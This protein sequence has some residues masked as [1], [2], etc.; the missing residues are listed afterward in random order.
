MEEEHWQGIRAP[1]SVKLSSLTYLQLSFGLWSSTS[2]QEKEAWIKSKYVEKRFLKKMSG[3]EALVEGER[4]ARPWTVKK[5]QRNNSSVRAPNRARRK[6]HRYEP[7]SASPANLSAGQCG[8]LMNCSV[9][10]WLMKSKS[11]KI[12]V[13]LDYTN[14]LSLKSCFF[15]LVPRQQLQQSFAG[16]PCSVRMSWIHYFPTLTL[17][18][19]RAVSPLCRPSCT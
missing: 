6:Y 2:R 18:L 12:Y 7:G 1:F 14:T 17:A 8:E 19:A 9:S 16:T 4:K 13:Y 10:V 3:S 5:C 15:T 11:V